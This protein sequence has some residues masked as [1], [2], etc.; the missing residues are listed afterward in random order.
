MWRIIFWPLYGI[1]FVSVYLL[2]LIL[3]PLAAGLGAIE[4]A[5]DY[6]KANKNENPIVFHFKWKFMFP[7]DNWEDGIA[8]DMYYKAPNLFLQIL[9]WS[10]V[11]N[12]TNNL[13]ITPY[14]S[15]KIDPRKVRWVGGPWD[16]PLLY[17]GKPPRS[18]WFF[19]WQGVYSNFWWQFRMFGH[20]WRSWLGWKIFPADMFE[21]TGHRKMGAGFGTQFKK[22]SK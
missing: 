8:N 17:D 2:G 5:Y 15:L 4:K 10:I 3:I 13:R 18:E 20:T 14:I 11:R 22:V 7:W 19:A 21:V 16:S 1:V 6:E 12:P 9:Y